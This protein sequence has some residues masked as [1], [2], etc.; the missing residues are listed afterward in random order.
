MIDVMV[1]HL[2]QRI[3]LALSLINAH[4]IAAGILILA[5]GDPSATILISAVSILFHAIDARLL[6][7]L[8]RSH[9]FPFLL[10]IDTL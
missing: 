4:E 1:D 7:A 3:F 6:R 2:S 9:F 10:S 5:L 8:L